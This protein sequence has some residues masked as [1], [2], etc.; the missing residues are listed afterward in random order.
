MLE[1][2]EVTIVKLSYILAN[3]D[4]FRFDSN[5]YQKEFIN[6]EFLIRDKKY[7]R[8]NSKEIEI[9]SFGAY[10]L[11]NEVEYVNEGVPFIRGINMKKG[12]IQFN[13]MLFITHEAN[14]LLWKSEV[15]PGMI[16]LSMSGTIGEVALA[17]EKWKYPMNSNQDIAKIDTI[18]NLNNYYLYAF[19]LSKYGQNYLIREAR[20]SVQQHVFLSQIEKFEIPEFS[21]SFIKHIQSILEISDLKND[22]S[23]QAYSQAET[24]LLQSLGLQDYKPSI[25]PVNIKSFKESFQSSGRLD[26]EYYQKK[27]EDFLLIIENSNWEYLKDI[28]TYISNGNQPPYSENGTIKFFSQKWIGDKSIDYSF[29]KSDEE[30]LVDKAFFD[31]EKNKS[32][33]VTTGD[34]LYYSVGANLG[35]CHNYLEDEP[36]AV[37]SFINI[38]RADRTKINEI[39]LGVVLNSLVGRL[40]GEK[41]KSG[42]AQPYIYAK[43]L[44][45]FKIPI[46]SM[47]KQSE[48][49]TCIIN[50]MKLK[51]QSEHLLDTAKRAVE[52]A[53]EEG[54]E[55]AMEWMG[56]QSGQ[57]E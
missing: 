25:D 26:A 35:Y 22:L 42:M 3:N 44:R 1:G 30:P 32:S 36:I 45:E 7:F 15:K 8:L 55:K 2:L 29:L 18:G 34:I 17:S 27:Y 23:K 57:R 51:K 5:Y 13:D 53:I 33:L 31:E 37:G 9:K 39:Y 52:M 40:Q 24:L 28:T 4:I 16:L 47:A 19:L 48:I 6:A 49:S 10:S 46:L 21:T 41:E 54:E 11:N 38:I 56:A 14:K 12:R 43:S 20:G 50:G